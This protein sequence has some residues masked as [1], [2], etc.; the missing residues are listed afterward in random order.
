MDMPPLSG[1][2]PALPISWGLQPHRWATHECTSLASQPLTA[3]IP[4]Y[5]GRGL[6]LV[7]CPF[8]F[9]SEWAGTKMMQY[10]QVIIIACVLLRI[11]F[12]NRGVRIIVLWYHP[13]RW[14][15]VLLRVGPTSCWLSG[16]IGTEPSTEE[17]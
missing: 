16:K 9:R 10:V 15:K 17:F 4:S 6:G 7:W 14:Q 13:W 5:E 8:K 3:A 1:C 2:S 11:S 12:A